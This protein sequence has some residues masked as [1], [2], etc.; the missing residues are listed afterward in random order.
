VTASAPPSALS[1]A[2]LTLRFGG[3]TALRDL[4]LFVRAGEVHALLGQNGSGKSTL[5]KTLAG[6]YSPRGTPSMSVHGEA[7]SFGSPTAS[8]GAG[9]RFVHQDLA[10][11]PDLSITDNLALGESYLGRQWLDDRR[12]HRHA[13]RLLHRYGIDVD[14]A[15]LVRDLNPAQQTMVA[16]ARAVK[17]VTEQT[18]VLVLDE[19]TAALPDTQSSLIFDLI[20]RIRDSGGTTVYVTHR[21]E[22]IFAV[23]DRVTVLRD[24]RRIATVDVADVDRDTVVEMIVGRPL[25]QL[26]PVTVTHRGDVALTAR[27]ITGADLR[28]VDLD[29]HR[30]EIVGV[31][32]LSGS[33]RDELP[34]LLFGARSWRSGSVDL[35]GRHFGSLTPKVAIDNGLALIPAD[36]DA[37]AAFAGMSVRENVTLP[38]ISTVR[39]RRV[40]RRLERGDVHRWTAR[41]EVVPTDTEAIM[42][43]L[44]GGNQQKVILARWLRCAPQ[45][46]LLDEPTQGV[47]I[48][49][50]AAIYRDL[51]A[52][53]RG[54]LAIL[55]CS[56]DHE[57]LAAICDRVLIMSE[58]RIRCTVPA[59]QLSADAV[60]ERVLDGAAVVPEPAEVHA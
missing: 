28:G 44:S 27:G 47:D 50:K 5:I 52:A 30:G 60:T 36:R 29:L 58:G 40:S 57:E 10:L 54:G 12:E 4:D 20:R 34:H 21:I 41:L 16:V 25:T 3:T 7:V 35:N 46:L 13:R 39:F 2:D 26:Y 6:R 49:A 22:E 23:A 9:L 42:S 53:A 38:R 59:A 56:T 24:G 51:A 31:A 18:S 11:I 19:V 37:A 55:V 43:T 1:V 17:S 33:G 15:T 8:H 32:G 14:P 48:G 45:V